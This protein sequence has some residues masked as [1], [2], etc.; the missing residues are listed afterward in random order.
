MG[1]TNLDPLLP[2]FHYGRKCKPY[3]KGSFNCHHCCW[4]VAIQPGSHFRLFC[5]W[6]LSVECGRKDMS[7]IP[8]PDL[9]KP[10]KPTKIYKNVLKPTVLFPFPCLLAASR[11]TM[12]ATCGRQQGVIEFDSIFDVCLPAFKPTSLFSLSAPQH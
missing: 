9:F 11:T 1:P 6:V 7:T 4:E 8:W 2:M 10:F 5:D 12:E 3:T